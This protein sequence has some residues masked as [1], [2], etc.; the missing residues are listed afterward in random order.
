M[1][2]PTAGTALAFAAVTFAQGVYYETP[3]PSDFE[4]ALPIPQGVYYEM[5]GPSDRE[6]VPNS[7]IQISLFTT[8]AGYSPQTEVYDTI[9]DEPRCVLGSMSNWSAMFPST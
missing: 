6:Q 7:A 5:N 9:L 3:G 1:S 4:Q 8:D 2:R